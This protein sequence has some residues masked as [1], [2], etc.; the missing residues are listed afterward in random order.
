VTGFSGDI[1]SIAIHPTNPDKIA[2]ATT[3]SQK[4]YV[5]DN[6]GSNWTSY[7]LDLPNF[8]ARAL[9]WEDNGNDGLYLGMNYGVYYTDNTM[10]VWQPFSVNL[11]N[12]IIS[13]LEI[14]TVTNEIYAATYGRGLWKSMLYDTTLSTENFELSDVVVYPNPASD[15]L[16]VTLKNATVTEVVL[17][18]ALGKMVYKDN[19]S[20]SQLIHSV[21]VS[22]YDTGFYFLRIST[23]KGA[24]TKKILIK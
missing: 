21:D 14:N 23:S 22:S 16:H 20:D 18:D 4:V 9:V 17:F 10:S 6:G 19:K 5:T 1:N 11:P 15:K 3:G 8:S 24:V 2:I 13:E 7:L 12:V